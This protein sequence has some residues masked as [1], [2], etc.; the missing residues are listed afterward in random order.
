M[1]D[2]KRLTKK[3]RYG[4]WYTN[5]PI[6]DRGMT[7]EDGINFKKHYFENG[8]SAYDGLPIDR[9]AELENK[10]E[11][12]RL[13]ELPCKVGD[14][15][16]CANYGDKGWRIL[17]GYVNEINIDMNGIYIKCDYEYSLS[18]WHKPILGDVFFNIED[19]KKRLKEL[20]ELENGRN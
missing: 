6:Y 19:A 12:G 13:I 20:K 8:L 15:A 10:I 11:Q 18:F 16:Y 1:S 4:H 2:Y 5:E 3:D 9:L 17:K 7:S 14:T